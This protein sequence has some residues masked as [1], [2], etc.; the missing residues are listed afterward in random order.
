LREIGSAGL[1][2]RKVELQ[3]GAGQD[4]EAGAFVAEC[5]EKGYEV[6]DAEQ[7]PW[8]TLDS[9]ARKRLEAGEA[10]PEC[11]TI[12]ESKEAVI[13]PPAKPKRRG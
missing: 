5:R 7:V 8:N 6:S 4:N 2:K 9:F 12:F 1:I 3:F 11:F 10:L 13:V